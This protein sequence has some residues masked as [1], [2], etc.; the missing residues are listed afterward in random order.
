M[1]SGWDTGDVESPNVLSCP[2][3]KAADA[4]ECPFACVGK[5]SSFTGLHIQSRP[6]RFRRAGM[7]SDLSNGFE[8]EAVVVLLP[9][10]APST[11]SSSMLISESERM[12]VGIISIRLSWNV[13]RLMG[14]NIRF[15]G[16]LDRFANCRLGNGLLRRMLL[17]PKHCG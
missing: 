2:D 8:L 5:V 3:G 7:P 11:P 14:W 10:G 12:G 13:T 4:D 1:V 6:R 17:A 15:G 16:R 9:A